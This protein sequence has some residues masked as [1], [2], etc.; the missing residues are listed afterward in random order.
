MRMPMS[1]LATLVDVYAREARRLYDLETSNE[2]TFYPAIERL[3][4]AVLE[5]ERLPFE[6]RIGTSERR[7]DGTDLPD[8]VLGDAGLFVAVFGEVKLPDEELS[9]TRSAA[10]SRRRGW[11]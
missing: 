10:I 2:A 4:T 11:F 5:H 1:S 3:L 7:A 8:F 6:V 9:E